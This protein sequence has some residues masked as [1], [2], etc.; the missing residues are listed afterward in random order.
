MG[1]FPECRY[2]RQNFYINDTITELKEHRK[3]VRSH[4]LPT[5][6][7]KAPVSPRGPYTISQ[8]PGVTLPHS[9]GFRRADALRH[10]R[11][12][13]AGLPKDKENRT[14]SKL[15]PVFFVFRGER[16]IIPLIFHSFK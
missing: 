16:G 10:P 14:A 11:P 8:V 7:P 12:P 3:T 5:G 13:A 6:I 1:V 4:S 15:A 2:Y 9:P